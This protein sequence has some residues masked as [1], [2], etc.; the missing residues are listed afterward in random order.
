MKH[1]ESVSYD[2]LSS[3]QIRRLELAY[4]VKSLRAHFGESQQTFSN[5]FALTLRSIANYETQVRSPELRILAR[6]AKTAADAGRVDLS[7]EFLFQIFTEL[8]LEDVLGGAIKTWSPTKK[9][10][11]LLHQVQGEQENRHADAYHI[12]ALAARYSDKQRKLAAIALLDSLAEGVA[13]MP[14]IK[15]GREILRPK[16]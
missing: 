10:G 11:A 6:F 13:K 2:R 16:G 3:E 7:Y 8:G 9:R 14:S 12:A 4:A 5:R 15:P 1:E